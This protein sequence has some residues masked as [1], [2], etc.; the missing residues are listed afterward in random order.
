MKPIKK[1]NY[2]AWQNRVPNLSDAFFLAGTMLF[3]TLVVYGI[4]DLDLWGNAGSFLLV[5]LS[6][7]CMRF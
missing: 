1:W 5:G 4:F 6:F 3:A 7:F 2:F